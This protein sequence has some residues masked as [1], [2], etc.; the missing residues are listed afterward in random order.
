MTTQEIVDLTG[1]QLTIHHSFERYEQG[2]KGKK[3]AEELHHDMIALKNMTLKIRRREPVSVDQETVMGL[4]RA[5]YRAVYNPDQGKD[6]LGRLVAMAAGSCKIETL[7]LMFNADD[8]LCNV[9]F[10]QPHELT[11][12]STK[13]CIQFRIFLITGHIEVTNFSCHEEGGH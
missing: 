8:A 11:L 6:Y 10:F 3:A 12:Q 4:S 7:A 9:E 5:T 13:N 1:A 2:D